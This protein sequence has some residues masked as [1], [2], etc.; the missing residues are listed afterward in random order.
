[1]KFMVF[2]F[3][4]AL[5]MGTTPALAAKC[6]LTQEVLPNSGAETSRDKT[7]TCK[8]ECGPPRTTF[9]TTISIKK[10]SCPKTASPPK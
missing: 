3:A 4:A 5:L 2:A 6:I 1:M 9:S 8:Y 7:I 10:R